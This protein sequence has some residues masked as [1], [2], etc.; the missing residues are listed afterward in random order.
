MAL[1]LSGEQISR[2]RNVGTLQGGYVN[3]WDDAKKV[4]MRY[5]VQADG[6]LAKGQVFFEMTSTPGEGALDG[7]KVSLKIRSRR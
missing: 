2:A 7:M 6:S 1:S 5:E 3:N 4:V